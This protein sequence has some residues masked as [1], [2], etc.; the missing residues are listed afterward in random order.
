MAPARCRHPPS[1]PSGR[2]RLPQHR[3]LATAARTP[4]R[5]APQE[6]VTLPGTREER[7]AT[8]RDHYDS[9]ARARANPAARRTDRAR[10]RLREIASARHACAALRQ[11]DIWALGCLAHELLAGYSPFIAEEAWDTHYNIIAGS[12]SL[13]AVPASAAARAFVQARFLRRRRPQA[14]CP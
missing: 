5:A 10:R 3:P 1:D 6:I 11:V 9:S 13:G 14:P 8:G 7:A 12:V 2:P 4:C